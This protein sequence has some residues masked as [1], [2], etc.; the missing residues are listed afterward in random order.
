VSNINSRDRLPVY[1][2]RCIPKVLFKGAPKCDHDEV[3][4]LG[5]AGGSPDNV[6][7]QCV[8]RPMEEPMPAPPRITIRITDLEL[9]EVSEQV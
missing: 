4:S 6:R 8:S 2:I 5:R 7:P 3:G 9:L 1:L